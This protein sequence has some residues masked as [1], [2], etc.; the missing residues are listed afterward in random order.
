LVYER[1]FSRKVVLNF[2]CNHIYLQAVLAFLA[3]S[4][5]VWPVISRVKYRDKFTFHEYIFPLLTILEGLTC[6]E[7]HVEKTKITEHKAR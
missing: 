7:E 6:G 2:L 3:D 1:S 4:F 5:I